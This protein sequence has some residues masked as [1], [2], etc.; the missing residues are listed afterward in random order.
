MRYHVTLFIAVPYYIC[1]YLIHPLQVGCELVSKV[2]KMPRLQSWSFGESG[3]SLH[4][5]YSQVQFDQE[6]LGPSKGQMDRL[7]F[8]SF[9]KYAVIL[10]CHYSQIHWPRVVISDR[11]SSISQI[12]I[13]NHFLYLK[14]FNCVQTNEWCWIE[15]SV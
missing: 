1:I 13:F 2:T 14:R 7:Q 3:I 10:Q 15:L 11:I 9:E 4:C 12:E 5:H 8:W 6:C